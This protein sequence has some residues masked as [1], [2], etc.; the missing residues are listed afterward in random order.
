MK[1]FRMMVPL[2]LLLLCTSCFE[3]TEEV[4]VNVDG[5]GKVT[6]TFNFSE[7]RQSLVNYMKIGAVEGRKIPSRRQLEADLDKVLR[8]MQ[9]VKGMS[10]VWV[11]RDFENFIFVFSGEFANV[12]V[13]NKTINEVAAAMNRSI[14]PTLKEKN[15]DY[16]DRQFNRYFKYPLKPDLYHDAS[17]SAR[18]LMDTARLISIFR[19]QK[20][21]RRI[22]NQKALLSP[23]KKS[24]MLQASL[25]ELAK[26]EVML[27]NTISF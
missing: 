18:Y 7:S 5:S 22:S 24:V 15:F 27:D 6:L 11:K 19:F 17:L 16:S 21:V 14:Y 8:T 10:N 13:L 26:G 1:Y 23:S 3:V 12:P 9:G 20:P 4:I 2:M 25:A